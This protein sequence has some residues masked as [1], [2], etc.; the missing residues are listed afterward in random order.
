[1]KKICLFCKE[2]KEHYA[3]GYCKNCYAR[4]KRRGTPEYYEHPT[5]SWYERNKEKA[6]KNQK[7]YRT[8]NKDKIEKTQKNYYRKNKNK[9]SNYKKQW[10]LKNRERIL[11]KYHNNKF[12]SEIE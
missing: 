7:K 2:E 1:M 8:E 4:Y 10:Y 9:I 6:K 12:K 3:K 5:T 11:E